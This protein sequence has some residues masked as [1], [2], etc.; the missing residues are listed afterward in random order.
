MKPP[1]F[2]PFLS[3]LH[4][5]QQSPVPLDD[6][7]SSDGDTA[8]IKFKYTTPYTKPTKEADTNKND[9]APGQVEKS[10]DK[11]S[12]TGGSNNDGD[13]P[14][15]P[16]VEKHLEQL[17]LS[18]YRKSHAVDQADDPQPMEITLEMTPVDAELHR[19]ICFPFL[20]RKASE[21]DDTRRQ[22]YFRMFELIREDGPQAFFQRFWDFA[23][24]MQAER[25]VLETT[26][27]ADVIV[28]C[29]EVFQVK[30]LTSNKSIQGDGIERT[31]RHVI[32]ME[33]D[34]TWIEDESADGGDWEIGNWRVADIDDQL[35]GKSWVRIK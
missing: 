12:T 15:S 19:L 11:D 32:R 21:Q 14:T 20:S 26:V 29:I 6:I 10:N 17:F 34:V 30:D 4:L 22:D 3:I 35:E 28:D 33:L 25:G 2:E 8:E 9:A 18:F 24:R 7:Y 23:D 1:N 27:M 13:D 5:F 31:V 16:L